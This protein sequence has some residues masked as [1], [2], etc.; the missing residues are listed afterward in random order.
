MKLLNPDP[1]ELIPTTL[2][3]EQRGHDEKEARVPR[4][5]KLILS[6]FMQSIRVVLVLLKSF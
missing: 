4:Q 5:L 2:A 6:M 3:E 1:D